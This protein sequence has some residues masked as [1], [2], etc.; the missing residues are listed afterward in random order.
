MTPEREQVEAWKQNPW[1]KLPKWGKWVVGALGVFIAIG[2][3]GAVAEGESEDAQPEP[4]AVESRPGP[5][6]H[7]EPALPPEP[8]A[9]E[10]DEEPAPVEEA[11]PESEPEPV[12][13]EPSPQQLAREA[14]GDDVSSDLAIGESEVRSVH[15]TGQLMSVV[16]STPEGG[17]EGPSTDDT[18][19]IAS[20]AL[21]KVYEDA[22]WRGAAWVQFRG[23]LASSAT[24]RSLPN[25]EAFAYRVERNEALRIDWSDDEALYVIDWGLY[26]AFCHPAFKGC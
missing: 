20:V 15:R 17:F 13:R 14:L 24:G 1:S 2:I 7:S 5:G 3:I 4:A 8:P 18:D 23:G 26:R 10:P 16:L 11:K 6:K 25:A 22:G 21:A 9:P 12:E 19:A